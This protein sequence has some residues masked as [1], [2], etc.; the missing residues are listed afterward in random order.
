[1]VKHA[2]ESTQSYVEKS[3]GWAA[4]Q[5]ILGEK[6]QHLVH[7]ETGVAQPTIS[8]I[9]RLTALPSRRAAIRF[10][11]VYAIGVTWWDEPPTAEQRRALKILNS[12][13]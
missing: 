13:A 6:S 11:E 9:S 5:L 4:L 1:M 7:D 3:R 2:A 12:A 10:Q 8:K